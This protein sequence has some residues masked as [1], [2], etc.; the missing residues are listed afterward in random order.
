AAVGQHESGADLSAG[1]VLARRAP[2]GRSILLDVGRRQ[3]NNQ[4]VV[5]A[6]RLVAELGRGVRLLNNSHRSAGFVVLKAPD[7]PSALVELGCLS[8]RDEEKMLRVATYQK[9]LAT[10]ILRSVN[11]YF[12]QAGAS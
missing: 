10:S 3:T 4:A 12:D 1:M 7:I 9:K 5:L 11:D 8:N 6:R 2:E